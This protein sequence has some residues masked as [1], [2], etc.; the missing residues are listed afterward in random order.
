MQ[1]REAGE[2]SAHQ[3]GL[4]VRAVRRND[5]P[6]EGMQGI[7]ELRAKIGILQLRCEVLEKKVRSYRQRARRSKK[8]DKHQNVVTRPS[9]SDGRGNK[10]SVATNTDLEVSESGTMTSM[11]QS[12]FYQF[13]NSVDN[14]LIETVTGLLRNLMKIQRD[15]EV[16]IGVYR[17]SQDSEC[18]DRI[19]KAEEDMDKRVSSIEDLCARLDYA[20]EIWSRYRRDP[21]EWI[22]KKD[23]QDL[24]VRRYRESRGM[25]PRTGTT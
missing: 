11:T 3:D 4:R 2:L 16:E 8:E 21:E 18:R 7:V 14:V 20:P 15:K 17:L 13:P 23:I 10:L 22:S 6:V 24:V 12:N 25:I 5:T 19:R 9:I 1:A